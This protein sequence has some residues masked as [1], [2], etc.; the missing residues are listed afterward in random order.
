[1]SNVF[2]LRIVEGNAFLCGALCGFKFLAAYNKESH[3]LSVGVNR[4]D[5]YICIF[6]NLL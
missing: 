6:F 4:I 2:M 1:M 5:L 3:R